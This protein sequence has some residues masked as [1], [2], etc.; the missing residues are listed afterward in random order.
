MH[1][2]PLTP[3]SVQ[4]PVDICTP[5]KCPNRENKPI[6]CTAQCELQNHISAHLEK[7][8][9]R[10]CRGAPRADVEMLPHAALATA[11]AASPAARHLQTWWPTAG[12]DMPDLRTPFL[13]GDHKIDIDITPEQAQHR[14]Q[15]TQEAATG[16]KDSKRALPARKGSQTHAD[17]DDSPQSTPRYPPQRR[18]K[19]SQAEQCDIGVMRP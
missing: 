14:S 17:Y 4:K 15:I 1:L 19:T 7:G 9:F 16:G 18:P 6:V 13:P 5:L 8:S 3:K 2:K 11:C 10:P 12:S